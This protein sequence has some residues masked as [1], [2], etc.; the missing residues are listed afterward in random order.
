MQWITHGVYQS[1]VHNGFKHSRNLLKEIVVM[2][3]Y[4]VLRFWVKFEAMFLLWGA[5]MHQ[6]L[7]SN[8]PLGLDFDCDNE[9]S[10]ENDFV[11]T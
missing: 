1:Q 6:N 7:K 2:S 9:Q 4:S 8:W 5:H 11:Q 10:H 3:S